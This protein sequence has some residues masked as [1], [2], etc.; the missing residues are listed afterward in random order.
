[1]PWVS[2]RNGNYRVAINTTNGTKIRETIDPDATEFLPE[3]PE[4]MDINIT[5]KCDGGCKFCYADCTPDGV[6]ASIMD[7]P[8]IDTL[9]SWTEVALQVNDLSHPDLVLFLEKLKARHVIANI[10]VNQK[11]FE[12]HMGFI[13]DLVWRNLIYGIGVSLVNPT[14]EFLSHVRQFPNAVVH[15]I[16]G[17]VTADDIEKMRDKNIK[18]LILGYKDIGR[19]SLWKQKNEVSINARQKY[20][21]DVLPDLAKHFALVSF[22]N[23]A[24]RQLDVRRILPEEK[25]REIYMGDDGQFTFYVDMVHQRYGISSLCQPQDMHQGLLPDVRDMFNIVRNKAKQTNE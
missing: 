8:F 4:S 13:K 21:Y 5:Q 24:L 15:V 22:D 18:L 16:N 25:W 23:L 1:M 2:Y 17:I 6:H 9:H 19:G 11:H 3:F 20:L 10:T 14:Q 7:V 12:K